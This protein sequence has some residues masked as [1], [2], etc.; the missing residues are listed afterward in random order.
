MLASPKAGFPGLGHHFS[1]RMAVHRKGG[2]ANRKPGVLWRRIRPLTRQYRTYGLSVLLLVIVMTPWLSVPL[3]AQANATPSFM[4]PE[5][6]GLVVPTTTSAVRIDRER[7][8]FDLTGDLNQ[9]LVKASYDLA[10]VSGQDVSLDLTFIAS[11]SGALVVS[12]DGSPLAV[13]ESPTTG[14]P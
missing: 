4:L 2:M 14:L 11:Q 5:S 3:T 9:A 7:L 13:T 8:T 10:N 12:L 6:G 1:K